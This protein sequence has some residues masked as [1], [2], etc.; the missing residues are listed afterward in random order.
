MTIA[1]GIIAL[2][3]PVGAAMAFEACN[4]RQSITGRAICDAF[5]TVLLLLSFVCS[6]ALLTAPIQ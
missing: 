3:L 1:W 6:Y 4:Q 2:A 5:A